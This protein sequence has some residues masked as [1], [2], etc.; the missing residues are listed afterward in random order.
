MRIVNR[1]VQ[2]SRRIKRAKGFQRAWLIADRLNRLQDSAGVVLTQA[3]VT[4]WLS[5]Q[6]RWA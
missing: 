2:V 4:Q 1:K 6:R 5:K 3:L